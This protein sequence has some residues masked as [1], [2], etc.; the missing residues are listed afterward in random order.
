VAVASRVEA[1]PAV[2]WLLE[3]DEP[4]IAAMARRDLL[5]ED[6]RPSL[7]AL[8]RGPNALR[9]LRAAGRHEPA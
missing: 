8:R 3:S 4:A 6:V 2:E 1:G 7:D 9:I 5:D